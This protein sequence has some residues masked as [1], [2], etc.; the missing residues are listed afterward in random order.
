MSVELS[1]AQIDAFAARTFQGNQA[2]VIPLD[3]WLADE[4]LQA[5]AEENNVAETAFFVRHEGSEADYELRWFTPAVEVELCG[6]A[7]L[8]S[9]H[10][11]LSRDVDLNLVRFMTRQAGVLEVRRANIGYELDLP[12]RRPSP[13]AVDERI[14]KALGAEPE[15]VLGFPGDNWI[16][17]FGEAATI[18]DLQPDFQLLRQVG[19]HLV[20]ATAPGDEGY[21]VVSRVFA[22]GAG[23]D[24]DPVTGAAHAILTPYWTDRLGRDSFRA[25]QASA[26]G[27]IVECRIENG[28]AVL[29]G[30]CVTVINGTFYL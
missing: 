25:Y 30:T 6:H 2:G 13:A 9:G 17:V 23:I 22:A 4:V 18:R 16:Y 24:E 10:Y 20:I 21:D 1:F 7:T 3:N 12:A 15:A 28:R 19:N 8:A 5:I 27:G 29:G 26:R 14:V 11:L